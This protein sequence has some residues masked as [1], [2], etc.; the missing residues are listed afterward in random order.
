MQEKDVQEGRGEV[1]VLGGNGACGAEEGESTSRQV[2]RKHQELCCILDRSSI[3]GRVKIECIFHSL[4]L[5][6]FFAKVCFAQCSM[7]RLALGSRGCLSL[8]V[9]MPK[10]S[11]KTL[12]CYIFEKPKVQG[13]QN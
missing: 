10:I 13:H 5:I 8:F 7:S 2:R 9:T 6:L 11:L 4:Q 12:Y 1:A 3:L